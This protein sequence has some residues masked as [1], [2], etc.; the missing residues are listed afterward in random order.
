VKYIFVLPVCSVSRQGNWWCPRSSS[1]PVPRT[2]TLH[3]AHSN[4]HVPPRP[5]VYTDTA[6]LPTC[7]CICVCIRLEYQHLESK[8][9]MKVKYICCVCDRN[10][11]C[12]I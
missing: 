4:T 12:L 8:T 6:Q 2:S 7:H 10:T 1:K 11:E 9:S 3:K 5:Y